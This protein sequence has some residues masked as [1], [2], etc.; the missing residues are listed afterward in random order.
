MN[1][2]KNEIMRKYCQVFFQTAN[3]NQILKLH[4]FV[5]KANN[6]WPICHQRKQTKFQKFSK[7]RIFKQKNSN[8]MNRNNILHETS[9]MKPGPGKIK[10]TGNIR[11]M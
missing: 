5:K 7:S 11:Q 10:D 3:R 9:D 1:D 2:N 8:I 6:E 4:L